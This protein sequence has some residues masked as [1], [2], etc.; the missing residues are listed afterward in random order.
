MAS[1][2]A[3]HELVTSSLPA[4]APLTNG[5]HEQPMAIDEN[6]NAE[7]FGENA[8]V[9]KTDPSLGVASV[10]PAHPNPAAPTP[11]ENVAPG[12]APVAE[13]VPKEAPTTSHPTPPPDEPLVASEANIDTEMT[14]PP[15]EPTPVPAPAPEPVIAPAVA[16]NESS[17]VRPREDD[18]EDEENAERAAKRS[19]T[20]DVPMQDAP[21]VESLPVVAQEDAP[22]PEAPTT[23]SGGE[24]AAPAIPKTESADDV[25]METPPAEAPAD[26]TTSQQQSDAP[27]TN[28]DAIPAASTEASAPEAKTAESEVK[29]SVEAAAAPVSEAPQAPAA[30]SHQYSKEPMT[31]GQ[32]KFLIEKMKNLKKTKNSI[33]FLKPVDPVAMAIP[34][35]PE[36]IKNPMDLSTMEQKLKSSHY[37]TVQEFADDFALIINNS[38]TFNGPNHAVTQAGMAMEAYFRKMMETVP[39]ADQQAKAQAKKGSPKPPA[40][41][42]RESRSA[43][44]TAAPAPA[45]STAAST[46]ASSEPFALQPDGTP[47]IRRESTTNRP[48]R[49]IKPPPAKELAYAKPKRK[50]HQTELKFV[51]YVLNQLKGPKYATVNHVFQTPVDPVALNIPQYRQIVKHPMDLS[52]MT[53]KLNQGQYGRA[54]EFKKDFELMVQNCLAFNPPGNAIRDLGISFQREFEDLWRTKEQWEKRRKAQ[55][56]RQASVSADEESAEEEEEEEDPATAD[57]AATIAALQKQLADMQSALAGLGG[58]NQTKPKKA[59]APKASSKK[60]GA[61]AAKAAK[62][63]AAK[64]KAKKPKQV[65]YEEKQEIS[66]AVGNMDAGQVEELTRIITSNCKKYADQEEMELEIDDLPNDVQAMLLTYVRSIFGNPNKRARQPSPDDLAAEDDD[67]FAPSARGGRGGGGGKRKKHKPMGKQ[68]QQAAISNIQKQLAQFQNPGMSGSGSP[69]NAYPAQDADTSGD[70]ESEES[71]EE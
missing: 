37:K 42:R 64:S 30:K 40:P 24:Q 18:E 23:E 9:S 44:V 1:D 63:A 4:D 29:P 13:F 25:A 26:A 16:S 6:R 67:D 12:I 61:P 51:E 38:L 58:G 52:T 53:Q 57:P 43:A 5:D 31:T 46:G 39:S 27:L 19:R 15:K 66:E 7:A 56:V 3:Q 70:D 36:I 47:Q 34:T 14:A 62:P 20:E 22:A 35:Y 60:G 50:E 28:G 10:A 59:K 32:L 21:A 41:P 17:L 68:E 45:L 55:S 65:T 54:A 33:Y 11:I 69:M 71:E 8:A 48:A 49:T 2:V